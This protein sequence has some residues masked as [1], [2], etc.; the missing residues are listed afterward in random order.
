MNINV[1]QANKISNKQKNLIMFFIVLFI[2]ADIFCENFIGIVYDK[3]SSIQQFSLFLSFALLQILFAPIQSGL[4]DIY[5]R[6]KSLIVSLSFSFLSLIFIA[7]LN[8]KVAFFPLLIM[9]TISKGA[10]GNTLP[11]SLALMADFQDK[12]YRL[13]FAFATAAYALAYLILSSVKDIISDNQINYISIVLFTCLIIVCF[14]FLNNNHFKLKHSHLNDNNSALLIIKNESKLIKKDLKNV[15]TRKALA[16][17]FFWET[18]LYTILLTQVD[19]HINKATHIAQAMMLGYL[20]GVFILIFCQKLKDSKIIKIGYLT[21]FFSLIP[22]FLLFKIV[23]DQN[24][25][26]RACYFFHALGNA[27]LSPALLSI[28]AKERKAHER[29][30]IYGLTDS[31]DTCGYLIAA[32]AIITYSSLKLDLIYLISFSFLTFA[33]SWCFYGRFQNI[34]E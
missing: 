13:S 12:N 10:I 6:K 30:R 33:I 32:L 23:E 21:S 16:A 20:S 14:R 7:F 18:S 22:Y 1:N 26:I 34:K 19:F 15:S 8:L 4:S 11:I 17:F 25:L 31:V 9:A 29:G 3:Q 28:L 2:F 27:F 5:G 24:S